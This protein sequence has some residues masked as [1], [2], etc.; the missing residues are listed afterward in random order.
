M[1]VEVVVLVGIVFF[2]PFVTNGLVFPSLGAFEVL[3]EM[4]M[5][6]IVLLLAGPM[7]DVRGV[8]KDLVKFKEENGLSQ[9]LP[10][11]AIEVLLLG[12]LLFGCLEVGDSGS[13]VFPGLR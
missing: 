10:L 13:E 6:G 8:V 9:D 2:V 7:E 3:S 12:E 1:L 11:I 5:E 4:C